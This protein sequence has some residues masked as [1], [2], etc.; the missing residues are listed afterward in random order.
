[1]GAHVFCR[2]NAAIRLGQDLS[3][4]GSSAVVSRCLAAVLQLV[5]RGFLTGM[6]VERIRPCEG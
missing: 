6:E 4:V 5:L 1:M 3:K 2:F